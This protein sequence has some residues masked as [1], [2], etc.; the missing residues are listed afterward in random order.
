MKK[1]TQTNLICYSIELMEGRIKEF[2]NQKT[3]SE[4]MNAMIDKCTEPWR[5][6]LETLYVMYEIENGCSF[7]K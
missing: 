6:T 3:G 1:V 2:E 5:E 4:S 7:Y